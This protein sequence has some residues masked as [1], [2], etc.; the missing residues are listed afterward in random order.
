M[1]IT[2]TDKLC[3]V[4]SLLHIQNS[5]FPSLPKKLNWIWILIFYPVYSPEWY[6]NLFK[7]YCDCINVSLFSLACLGLC[8]L[9]ILNEVV[10]RLIA[11]VW[12]Q[13]PGKR[14]TVATSA[15]HDQTEGGEAPPVRSQV[16]PGG[17]NENIILVLMKKYF[18]K[19]FLQLHICLNHNF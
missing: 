11:L 15:K 2:Q 6:V 10:W 16:V 19:L 14:G 9:R 7:F 3:S 12:R 5:Q 17:E 13:W 1:D 4:F 18:V 8:I